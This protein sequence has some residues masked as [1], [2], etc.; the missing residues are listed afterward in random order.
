MDQDE[1]QGK[2][3]TRSKVTILDQQ[4]PAYFDLFSNSAIVYKSVN[5]AS[6]TYFARFLMWKVT[7]TKWLRD[8]SKDSVTSATTSKTLLSVALMRSRKYTSEVN[9]EH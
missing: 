5:S 9:K 8:I 3:T 6:E 1:Q 7:K 4:K 2:K